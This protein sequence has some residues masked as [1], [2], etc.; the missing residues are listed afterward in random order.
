[1]SME[2]VIKSYADPAIPMCGIQNLRVICPFQTDFANMDG[3]PTL[4]A[5]DCCCDGRAPLVQQN[6]FH[7]TRSMLMS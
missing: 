1:M 7:A 2:V 3:V 6:A 4:F 5:E